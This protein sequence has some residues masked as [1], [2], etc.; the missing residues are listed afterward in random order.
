MLLLFILLCAIAFLIESC[1]YI[2][3]PIMGAY[4]YT[5]QETSAISPVR[6]IPIWIDKNFGEADR[7]EISNAIAQ[8]NYALNG[9]VILNVVDVEF[10]MEPIKIVEQVRMN[11][12]L[13]MKIDSSGSSF[14]PANEKPGFNCIGFTER[15]GGNHLFLV[16]DRLENNE[17]FG[18]TL[19]EIGHLLG[20]PHVGDRLMRAHF[21]RATA[22]CI[23][24]LTIEKVAKYA[25]IP[26]GNLNYCIDATKTP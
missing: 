25:G 10:D 16:R 19:H 6:V 26:V 24:F 5:H 22:Q 13:F 3:A 2:D 12:W 17:V 8:W 20:S 1:Q 23:D 9:Y 21:T 4:Q 7:I 11:G 14:I 15:L 18:V